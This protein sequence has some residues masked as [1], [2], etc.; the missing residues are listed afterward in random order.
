MQFTIIACLSRLVNT[1]LKKI[2][3]FFV[4]RFFIGIG[5]ILKIVPVIFLSIDG[6]ITTFAVNWD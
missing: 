1:F 6:K 3:Y 2:H 5:A 4:F